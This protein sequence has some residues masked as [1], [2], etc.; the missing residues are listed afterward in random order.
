M[1]LV[2]FVLVMMIAMPST[3]NNVALASQHEI[4]GYFASKSI[5]KLVVSEDTNAR[6]RT[7]EI[8]S[9]EERVSSG[10][11][12][13]GEGGRAGTGATTIVSTTTDN[14]DGT[15]T[16]SKYYNNGLF[17]KIERWWDHLLHPNSN[18]RLRQN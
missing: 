1:R 15:V 10:V 4:T 9:T 6:S 16:V 7:K 11:I 14:G 12:A 8:P 5:R 2:E 17:Q 18:R 13:S 3:S